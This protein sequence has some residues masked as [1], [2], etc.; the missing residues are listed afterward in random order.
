MCKA[1]KEVGCAIFLDLAKAFD[2]VNH[3]ILLDKLDRL[4]I[5]GP[6]LSWFKSDLTNRKTKCL[7]ES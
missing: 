5:R 2:N 3:K 7:L 1:K 4:G 6:V